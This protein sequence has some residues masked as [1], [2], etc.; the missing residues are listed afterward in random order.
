MFLNSTSTTEPFSTI[1]PGSYSLHVNR[2]VAGHLYVQAEHGSGHMTPLIWF[3]LKRSGIV[4]V[5]GSSE[6][7]CVSITTESSGTTAFGLGV[8]SRTMLSVFT[9]PSISYLCL[10]CLSALDASHGLIPDLGDGHG[11]CHGFQIFIIVFSFNLHVTQSVLDYLAYH[12]SGNDS[13]HVGL[14]LG[15]KRATSTTIFG[16]SAGAPNPQKD[17]M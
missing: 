15:S 13:A 14:S 12:R 17:A 1:V 6:L 11:S 5:F 3:C 8:C 10:G 7:I 4:T 16:S 9:S 2:A